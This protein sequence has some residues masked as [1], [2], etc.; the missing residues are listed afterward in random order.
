MKLPSFDGAQKNFQ[1]WWTQFMAFVAMHRFTQ[2]LVIGGE[3][4]LLKNEAEEMNKLMPAG[5]KRLSTLRQNALAV[6]N[7]TRIDLAAGGLRDSHEQVPQA[8]QHGSHQR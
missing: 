1:M 7:L 4:N 8:D 2:V 5:K 3:A 6:A